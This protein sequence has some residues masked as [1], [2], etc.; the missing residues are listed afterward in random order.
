MSDYQEGSE[1]ARQE[2]KWPS[3]VSEGMPT[4]HRLEGVGYDLGLPLKS[5][6]DRGKDGILSECSRP[7]PQRQPEYTN[8]VLITEDGLSITGMITADTANSITLQRAEGESDTVLRGNIDE[9][10]D[11]G[12][13]ICP[14]DWRNRSATRDGPFD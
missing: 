8:Y 3:G 6:K 4:C 5:I 9:L 11:T 2:P 13:S 10:V 14:K 7:E 12:V 1:N